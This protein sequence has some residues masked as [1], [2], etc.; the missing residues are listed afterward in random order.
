MHISQ[1]INVNTVYIDSISQSKMAVLLK[2]SQL[3][4]QNHPH[5]NPQELFDAYWKRECLGST[6]IGQ[7]VAIPHIRTAALIKPQG[8]V[9]RL[10]N[11]VDFGAEDKQPI[12][13]IIGL[14]VPQEQVDQHL[15]ILAA[16]IKQFSISSFR[17]ACRRINEQEE[18]YNLL[19]SAEELPA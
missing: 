3:V 11:P 14:L 13:L 10:L 16:I 7:G 19:I 2:L 9:I 8:C 18:F 4:S 6:A 1:L 17:E 5:L 12:D 15:K